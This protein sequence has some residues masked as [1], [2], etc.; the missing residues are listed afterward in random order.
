MKNFTRNTFL[1]LLFVLA[2]S[3]SP[4]AAAGEDH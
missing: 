1:I 4:T 2:T 3:F